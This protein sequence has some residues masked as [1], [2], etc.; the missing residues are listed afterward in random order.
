MDTSNSGE[1]GFIDKLLAD[2][3][4]VV[5]HPFYY[6]ARKIL[7]DQVTQETLINGMVAVRE[8]SDADL[9]ALKRQH[10]DEIYLLRLRLEKLEASRSK[11]GNVLVKEEQKIETADSPFKQLGLGKKQATVKQLITEKPTSAPLPAV[12]KQKARKQ[13]A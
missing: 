10:D 5:K 6:I 13:I 9:Q 7:G 4:V 8:M 1:R 11:K 12:V 2:S 3:L